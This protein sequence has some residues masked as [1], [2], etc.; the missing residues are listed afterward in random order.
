MDY[1]SGNGQTVMKSVIFD[2]VILG[3]GEIFFIWRQETKE[4]AD[5]EMKLKFKSGKTS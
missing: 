3:N 5:A 4:I 1:S 2:E